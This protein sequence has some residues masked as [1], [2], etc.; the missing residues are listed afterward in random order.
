MVDQ[1]L[2]HER[3]VVLDLGTGAAIL[4]DVE[5]SW[6]SARTPA[7][8]AF[9]TTR[10]H[11]AEGTAP[12]RLTAE[13]RLPDGEWEV[14]VDLSPANGGETRHWHGRVNLSRTPWWKRDNLREGP[15]IFPVREA[16][17]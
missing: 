1:E 6:V 15:V 16:L 5:L 12:A 4:S 13:V 17:R 11:F 8:E 3:A 2:S 10:W 9:L 7:D 14:D